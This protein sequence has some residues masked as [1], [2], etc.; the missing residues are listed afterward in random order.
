MPDRI[1][2]VTILVSI[3]CLSSSSQTV[4]YRKLFE[5]NWEKAEKFEKENK[6]WMDSILSMNHIDYPIAIAVIFPELLRYSALRDRMETSLLKSLYVNLGEEYA[7]FSIGRFQMKPSFAEV[8]RSKS[9][10]FYHSR[11]SVS[12]NGPKYYDDIKDFRKSIVA[13]LE[14]T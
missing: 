13:D 2:L 7:N 5:D 10:S 3:I 14:N 8:I 4:D 1:F 9:V 11:S 6:S 12:F